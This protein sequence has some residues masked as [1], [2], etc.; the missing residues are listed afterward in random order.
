M[1][2]FILVALILGLVLPG[3]A[4]SDDLEPLDLAF[5]LPVPE[6]AAHRTY[7]GLDKE[8]TFTLD[9]VDADILVIEI[10]SMYCPICQREAPKVNDLYSKLEA[11]DKKRIRLIGIGAGNSEFEVKFFKENYDIEFPLFSDGNFSIHKKIG[12]KGTPF[13][14]VMAPDR[15]EADRVLFTHTGEITDLAAFY[16]DIIHIGQ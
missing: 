2:V 8:G 5:S 12:E 1:R 9:Q 15:A 13:F 11:N 6:D 7:L 14:I 3:S 10:F 4:F 16:D